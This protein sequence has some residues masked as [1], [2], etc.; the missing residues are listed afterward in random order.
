M[1]PS[2]GQLKFM[3]QKLCLGLCLLSL[4]GGAGRLWGQITTVQFL[5]SGVTYNLQSR[6]GVPIS[7]VVNPAIGSN[8]KQ[9]TNN[10]SGS[11]YLPTTNQFAE[12]LSFGA[13]TATTNN[14]LLLL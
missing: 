9:P 7:T 13:V 10:A 1:N 8:G 3:K 2:K 12:M 6:Q 4:M 11:G 5:Q 14:S